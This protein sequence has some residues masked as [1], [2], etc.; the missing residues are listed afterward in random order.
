M[1]IL[2]L[3]QLG[4]GLPYWLYHLLFFVL[5]LLGIFATP[6]LLAYILHRLELRGT[7]KTLRPEPSPT[8]SDWL[9]SG[10]TDDQYYVRF[11]RKEGK[12]LGGYFGKNSFA[13]SS[14]DGQ[15]IYI[16]EVWRLDED[17]RFIE[18][19]EGTRGAIVNREDCELI[20]FFETREARE[21]RTLDE[22]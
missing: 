9:F 17:G 6:I 21:G 15:E 11:H 14:P 5:I 16:E 22:G 4:P 19:V 3:L 12:D 7:L 10:G 18:R 2:V 20:E 1:P 8:P 13:A